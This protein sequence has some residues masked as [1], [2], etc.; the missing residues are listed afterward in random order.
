MSS[1]SSSSAISFIGVA[2]GFAI[3]VGVGDDSEE[4]E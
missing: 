3:T 2:A 1:R 4:S